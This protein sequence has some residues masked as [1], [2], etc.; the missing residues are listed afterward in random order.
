MALWPDA[1][2]VIVGGEIEN[3]EAAIR[4][5]SLDMASDA[6]PREVPIV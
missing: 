2:W 3:S 6:L 1:V 5:W 4:A